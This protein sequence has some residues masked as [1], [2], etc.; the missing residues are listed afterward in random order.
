M[1]KSILTFTLLC[2]TITTVA[3][4][5][6]SASKNIYGTSDFEAIDK[7]YATAMLGWTNA[8]NA[9]HSKAIIL[10]GTDHAFA[11]V[12][13]M[14]EGIKLKH[15]GNYAQIM[16]DKFNPLLVTKTAEWLASF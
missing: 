14:E 7:E 2:S 3:A 8:K 13:S 10:E 4:Q 6:I 12:G 5:D 9:K 15:S 1:K 16:Q 11:L